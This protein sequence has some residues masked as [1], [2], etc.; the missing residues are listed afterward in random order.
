MIRAAH[1]PNRFLFRADVRACGVDS[2]L[3]GMFV[4]PATK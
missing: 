1:L 4:D 2:G 3:P